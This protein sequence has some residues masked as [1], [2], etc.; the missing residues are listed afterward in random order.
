MRE[1]IS[2]E[3]TISS[4]TIKIPEE[5]RAAMPARAIVMVIEYENKYGKYKP[6]LGRGIKKMSAPHI[7]TLGWKFNREEA[8]AR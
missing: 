5:Y 8:N 1:A 3:T 7:D 4:D 6:R 2:F